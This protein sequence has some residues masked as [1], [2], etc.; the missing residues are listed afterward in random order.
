MVRREA[1]LS[2]GGFDESERFS[3]DFDL[4]LRLARRSRFVATHEVTA[5]W[6]WHEAQQS[7]T[8]MPQL[9]AVYRFRAR[10]IEVLRRDGE[11]EQANELQQEFEEVW[12]HDLALARNGEQ[13]FDLQAVSDLA[14]LVQVSTQD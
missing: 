9:A 12:A 14:P 10:F 4:W 8:P 7:A 5:D 13:G 1:L 3:V 11:L 2:I 6:R